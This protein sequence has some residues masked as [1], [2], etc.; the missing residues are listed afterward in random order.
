MEALHGH[1]ETYPWSRATVEATLAW[2]KRI[3][4]LSNARDRRG[5]GYGLQAWEV[6]P[7]IGGAGG[8]AA[9]ADGV[10]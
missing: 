5:V 3:G 4:V 10:E 7:A 2:L 1:E 8:D 9:A 6:R